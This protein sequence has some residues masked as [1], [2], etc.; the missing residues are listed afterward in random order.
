MGVLQQLLQFS[1]QNMNA[2]FPTNM[3]RIFYTQIVAH[4]TMWNNIAISLKQP[5]QARLSRSHKTVRNTEKE[6]LF[7]PGNAKHE[8]LYITQNV[9]A[10][11]RITIF[12]EC[13]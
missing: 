8:H 2:I 4:I 1:T 6:N 3:C 12:A 13:W 11:T 5:I 9:I 10:I 7:F